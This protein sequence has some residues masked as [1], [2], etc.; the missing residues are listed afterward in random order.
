MIVNVN[1]N[2]L[3]QSVKM[4]VRVIGLQRFKFR[5]W[6]GTGLI[7]LGAWVV[8]TDIEVTL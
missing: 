8:G 6:L 3:A 1:V 4:E 5:V 7:R 2:D